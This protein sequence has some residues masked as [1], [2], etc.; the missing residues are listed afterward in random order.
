MN[1]GNIVRKPAACP[2][3][4]SHWLHVFSCKIWSMLTIPYILYVGI[5]QYSQMPLLNLMK[6]LAD[7]VT[8]PGGMFFFLSFCLMFSF[9]GN[10]WGISSLAVSMSVFTV[11]LFTGCLFESITATVPNPAWVHRSEFGTACGGTLLAG[12]SLQ[13]L[14]SAKHYICWGTKL[15]LTHTLTRKIREMDNEC[16]IPSISRCSWIVH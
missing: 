6:P 4:D 14:L 7:K 15:F 16:R 12:R 3:R 13:R 9:K 1:H 5:N 2:L 8:P 11:Y 10:E